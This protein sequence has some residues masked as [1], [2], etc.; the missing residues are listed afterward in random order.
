MKEN[1]PKCENTPNFLFL[2]PTG[3]CIWFY[4]FTPTTY[5][6]SPSLQKNVIVKQTKYDHLNVYPRA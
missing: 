6:I 2:L 3:K 1:K 5:S 4:S